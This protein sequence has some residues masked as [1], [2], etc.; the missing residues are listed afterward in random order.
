MADIYSEICV[1][2][3]ARRLKM[4]SVIERI[5]IS[6]FAVND[7]RCKK[8]TITNTTSMY[9]LEFVIVANTGISVKQYWNGK[10]ILM[11]VLYCTHQ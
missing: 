4:K 9:Y 1:K 2:E 5:V 6:K 7:T 3:V 8:R 11:M 10:S